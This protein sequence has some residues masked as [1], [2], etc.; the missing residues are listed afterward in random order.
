MTL[1]CSLVDTFLTIASQR[2]VRRYT[3]RPVPEEVVARILDAGRVAGSA[4]NRQPWTFVV[5]GD[6]DRRARL[7]PAVYEPSN[8]AGA[9]LCVAVLGSGSALDAGRAIQNMTLAAWNDG[10]GSCPNGIADQATAAEA[11]GLREGEEATIVLSFGYP[12]TA[13]DPE[14]RTA[15]EWIERA[16]RKPAGEIVR[17]L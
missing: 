10:V 14:R 16:D 17:R 12:R 15:G 13:R 7:A 11:L 5:L 6:P 9:A 3:D 4:R 1:A 8:I 2:A